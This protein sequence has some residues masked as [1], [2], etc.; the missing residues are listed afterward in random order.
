VD[1]TLDLTVVLPVYDEEA[2]IPP[3][4]EALERVLAQGGRSHEVLFVDDG[5]G[6]GSWDRIREAAKAHPAVRAI[7]LRRNFGKA[8]ALTAGFRAARGR[9]VVTMDADLQDDPDELA[10]LVAK[11]DEGYD[12]VSGWKVERRDPL[13]KTLPSKLFNWVTGR[14]TGLDLHDM[15]CG[16]KAYRREVVRELRVYG[17]LHR[18]IPVLAHWRGFRVGELAVLHHARRHGRSK[19]GLSRFLKGFVDLL[20]VMFLTRY[21]LRPLHLFGGAGVLIAGA[22]L[23]INL[24]LTALWLAGQGIGHRPLLQLGVLL[25]VVGM[26]LVFTG[27][28]GEMV[29]DRGFEP[30]STYSV[31]ETI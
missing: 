13:S 6:D 18:Y 25:C 28:I 12:L 27:L 1:E 20:T 22:G 2:S 30:E 19:Y 5:S 10:R 24:Y 8:A 21:T 3:L 9:V 14:L 17:E 11:L 4:A 7:R 29:A 31:R 26:Q 16:F 23:A 15:N